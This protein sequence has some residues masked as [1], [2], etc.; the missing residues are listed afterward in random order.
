L[1]AGHWNSPK[2]KKDTSCPKTRQKLQQDG[3]RGVITIK[4][5]SIPTRW[6]THKLETNTTKEALPLL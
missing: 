1:T 3:R 5:N 4:S 2:K 6:A